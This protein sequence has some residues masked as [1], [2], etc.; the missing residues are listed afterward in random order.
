MMYKRRSE[1]LA[2]VRVNTDVLD[3]PGVV[4]ADGNAQPADIQRSGHL[5]QGLQE[6][7]KIWFSQR[8]GRATIP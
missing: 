1:K 8:T 7:P 4:I 6:L 3:L 5:Q 2:V